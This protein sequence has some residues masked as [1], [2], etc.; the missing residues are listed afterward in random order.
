MVIYTTKNCPQCVFLKHKMR[1][2]GVEFEVCMD[3]AKIQEKGIKNV[4][5]VELDDGTLLAF[6]KAM[7]YFEKER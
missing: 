2:K 1:A 6:S 5:T 3:E 7:R 4:P